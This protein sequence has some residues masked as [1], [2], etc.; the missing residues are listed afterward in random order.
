MEARVFAYSPPERADDHGG[1]V[2]R[3][4]RSYVVRRGDT[5][6]G[7]AEKVLGTDDPA[8]IARYWPLIHRMNRDTVGPD[9]SLIIPGQVLELPPE[10]GR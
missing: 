7:I 8:R 10:R 5:L 3:G 2:P 6:W 9:P 4:G 1:V